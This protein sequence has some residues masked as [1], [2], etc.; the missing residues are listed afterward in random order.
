MFSN[1]LLRL[2]K[3]TLEEIDL[4]HPLIS[5]KIFPVI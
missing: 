2:D 3:L 5:S 4:M 1:F